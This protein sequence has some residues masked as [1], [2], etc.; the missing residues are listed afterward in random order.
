MS[1]EDVLGFLG[2]KLHPSLQ[3]QVVTDTKRRPQGWRIRHR[4]AGNW[5]KVYDKVSVLRVETTISN[6]RESRIARFVPDSSGRRE[7]RWCPMRKGVSDLWRTYQ[8]GIAANYRYLALAAAPLNGEGVAALDALCR[9]TTHRERRYARF[10]PSPP[11]TSPCSGPPSPASTPSKAWATWA[12]LPPAP[13]PA[14][15]PRP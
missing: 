8:V 3:A 2:R 6:P 1:S 11:T 4:M 7:R 13:R 14:P 9:P 5:V 12:M 15:Q 10:S